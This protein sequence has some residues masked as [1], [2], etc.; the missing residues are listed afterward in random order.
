MVCQPSRT[1]TKI[2][3]GYTVPRKGNFHREHDDE[4]R[5]LGMP[6]ILRQTH[7]SGVLRSWPVATLK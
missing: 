3:I 1:G 7:M 4:P 2:E 6:N 5:D